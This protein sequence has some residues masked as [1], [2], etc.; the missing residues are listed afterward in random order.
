[1]RVQLSQPPLSFE[2]T[3][4][5]TT[6]LWCSDGWVYDTTAKK[7][8]KYFVI[9]SDLFDFTEQKVQKSV[10]SDVQHSEEMTITQVSKSPLVWVE[11]GEE[12]ENMFVEV[13]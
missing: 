7:R 3:V 10:F 13:M 2:G 6:F 4:Y 1:M 5:K 11:I 9:T 8:R 12:T